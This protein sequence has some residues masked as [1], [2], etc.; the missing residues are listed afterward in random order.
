MVAYRLYMMIPRQFV[1]YT[2]KCISDLNLG[3][4][5]VPVVEEGANVLPFPSHDDNEARLAFDNNV[6]TIDYLLLCHNFRVPPSVCLCQEMDTQLSWNYVSVS[7]TT[8]AL[9]C[10][11]VWS[12]LYVCTCM[13]VHVCV[14]VTCVISYIIILF[15][16]S[17]RND[18]EFYQISTRWSRSI[19]RN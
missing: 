17:N 15:I 13:C 4:F 9:L 10:A 8:W 2:D 3:S 1:A 5:P 18:G 11:C 6:Y 12:C 19:T 14:H 16:F 7:F